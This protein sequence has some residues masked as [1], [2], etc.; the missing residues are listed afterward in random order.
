LEGIVENWSK[1]LQT[2]LLLRSATTLPIFCVH[3]A[4]VGKKMKLSAASGMEFCFMGNDAG[5]IHLGAFCGRSKTRAALSEN[6][7]GSYK[8]CL[9]CREHW[10]L[11]H[12]SAIK[13]HF[14]VQWGVGNFNSSRLPLN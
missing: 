8:M 12:F 4:S 6:F 13:Q 7:P 3:L 2:A 14:N 1:A 9:S 5:L 11:F 10:I